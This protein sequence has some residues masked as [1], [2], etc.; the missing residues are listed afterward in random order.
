M[1]GDYYDT[2]ILFI[3]VYALVALAI[4]LVFPAPFGKFYH[5]HHRWFFGCAVNGKLAWF[6]FES[7]PWVCFPLFFFN[8]RSGMEYNP[9]NITLLIL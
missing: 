5:S 6:I 8:A 9:I 4:L 1:G 7:I 2:A 3:V